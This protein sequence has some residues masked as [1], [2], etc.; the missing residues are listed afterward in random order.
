MRLITSLF[1]IG[2][3]A[4]VTPMLAAQGYEGD[5]P[6]RVARL[7]YVSG[8]VSFRP[9][10]ADDWT[11]ATLNYPLTTGDQLWTDE[12]SRAELHIGSAAI[13]LGSS[14]AMSVLAL[15]DRRV[16]LR[17]SQGALDL[18][19]R[20]LEPGEIVELD[21]PNGAVTILRPG[22]YRVDVP[23]S[24]AR[25]M[26][27][28]R[29]GDL[30]VVTGRSTF[31]VRSDETAVVDGLED[32]TYDLRP[33]FAPDAWEEWC[34]ARDR[35]EDEA[36]AAR[37]VS[38]EMIGYEDLDAYGR[39][40][41]E[42]GYGRVWVPRVF[43][44][45]APYRYGHWAWIPPWGWT[46]IDDAPWGFAPFHYGRWAHVHGRWVWVPGVIVARPVYAPALV[47]F[48]GG[49]GWH[50]SVAIG[51]GVGWF[52]LAPGEPYIPVYRASRTYVRQVN[53]T[54][55]RVT[56]IDITNIN[57]TNIRYAN[58]RV[59]G[60]VTVVSR[61]VFTG[62][63]PVGRSVIAV[64][65]R[66]LERAPVMGMGA[67]LAPRR[68][69]VIGFGGRGHAVARPPANVVERRV[70]T[71]HAPPQTS[72]GGVFAVPRRGVEGAGPGAAPPREDAR[73]VPSP[74]RRHE[75]RGRRMEPAAPERSDRSVAHERSPGWDPQ[76]EPGRRL[77]VPAHQPARGMD[78]PRPPLR[79]PVER[80]GPQVPAER[81]AREVPARGLDAGRP[82]SREPNVRK[83]GGEEKPT[84]RGRR[85][86]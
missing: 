39:W 14:T 31:R 86:Q 51:E 29:Q 54:N 27:T 30:E 67:R 25:T 57:V 80:W 38:R 58:R 62:A 71:R 82:P 81:R 2:I 83:R 70:V 45:W 23:E 16:Q 66:D 3:T 56:N 84:D 19:V 79:E 12:R 68:E 60:A 26:V 49:P 11:E 69:S 72:G 24:G 35:R 8:S 5:P 10:S 74:P 34:R 78:E 33:A 61:D 32:P 20:R 17:M 41:V 40:E 64:R 44:G 6:A 22:I 9:A 75:V 77:G 28:V 63:R 37:Y 65:E 18:R 50:V 46:W 55:V 1:V 7:S 73:R 4:A 53:I 59:P 13:R 36:I 21:T 15:D 42:V 76:P 85:H 47:A 48:V 52:P 43:V